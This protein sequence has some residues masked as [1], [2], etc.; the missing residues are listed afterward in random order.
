MISQTRSTNIK[1]ILT[2]HL[3]LLTHLAYSQ[4][5]KTSDTVT[6]PAPTATTSNSAAPPPVDPND[7]TGWSVVII[8]KQ[9]TQLFIGGLPIVGAVIVLASVY[10]FLWVPWWTEKMKEVEKEYNRLEKERMGG[11]VGRA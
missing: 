9:W 11:A 2:L 6:T 8:D 10:Q 3:S 7:T 5:T 4:S 1:Y